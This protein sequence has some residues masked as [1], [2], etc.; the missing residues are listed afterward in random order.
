MKRDVYILL[1]SLFVSSFGIAQNTREI[2]MTFNEADF[3][4]AT[5]SLGR[6]VITP[7]SLECFYDEE[8]TAPMLPMLSVKVVVG[9]TDVF[10]NLSIV[11]SEE[12]IAT[13]VVLAPNPEMITIST[14][15]ILEDSTF[16][17]PSGIYPQE[18]VR[19]VGSCNMD[20][21]NVFFL[22][23]CPF[24]YNADTRVL[25]LN[26]SLR[27]IIALSNNTSQQGIINDKL[28][29]MK[30][31][32]MVINPNTLDSLYSVNTPSSLD[33]TQ[34]L[35]ITAD[36]LKSSFQQ[37]AR[38]KTQK[39]VLTKILTTEEIA[40]NYSEGSVVKNI[41]KA[42]KDCWEDT[43]GRLKYVLLGGDKDIVR[44]LM[45]YMTLYEDSDYIPC[46]YYYA[47]L[48]DL[49]W[50]SSNSDTC[51]AMRADISLYP[52]ITVT[53]SYVETKEQA[54]NFVNKIIEYERYPDINKMHNNIL[55]AGNRLRIA[56]NNFEYDDSEKQSEMMYR[57]YIEPYWNGIR[58][59]FFNS[60]TDYPEGAD[61]EYSVEHMQTQLGK[62]YS[63]VDVN[64][65]GYDDSWNMEGSGYYY[66]SVNAAE[67]VNPGYTI[68][69]TESCLTAN[70]MSKNFVCLMESFIKNEKSG[71]LGY[72]GTTSTG[73]STSSKNVLGVS[74][75][76][77]GNYYKQLF[78]SNYPRFGESLRDAK[79][80]LLGK[81]QSKEKYKWVAL[82]LSAFGDAEMP[83]YTAVPLS[84][85]F[86]NI[87]VA[88]SAI[89]VNTGIPN[90]RIC[91]MST[92]LVDFYCVAD[93]VQS[94]TFANIPRNISVCITKSGFI[95]RTYYV[96]DTI[97]IQN[98]RLRG[99]RHYIAKAVYIG[100]DVVS[101]EQG[102]VVV[103]DG[104]T[105]VTGLHDVV[106]TKDFE[107]KPGAIFEII[108]N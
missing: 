33:S 93:S 39:G 42:I 104:K 7:D 28:A 30:I 97:Y 108:P 32:K 5:D 70:Y 77:N 88:D 75:E 71:I 23:V 55:M 65:H 21:C 101:K 100:S 17:Y 26:T 40:Q 69:T 15:S 53:R 86:I 96:G 35:I 16:Y 14:S 91:V 24:I 36:T 6:M 106:I 4:Y 68:I 12:V 47:C 52:N 94:Y 3:N 10:D 19:Y 51:Q 89:T 99:E 87:S 57:D 74:N 43:D 76:Y 25:K 20:G 49:D 56:G 73:K 46:D 22:K 37:L 90:C 60:Y 1:L 27:I 62:G 102:N 72:V 41:K 103:E 11:S 38:W 31:K 8:T 18:N 84:F 63:F 105:V 80:N 82:G 83:V 107:V 45:C 64:C 66:T 78:T 79:I 92:D 54:N 58:F 48:T 95:P 2:T 50:G 81:I 59:R 61:Y 29:K 9:K 13:S 85:N 98:E 67:L 34:Y 44:P